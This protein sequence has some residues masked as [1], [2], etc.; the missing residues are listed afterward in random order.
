MR[1][2]TVRQRPRQQAVAVVAGHEGKVEPGFLEERIQAGGIARLEG[3]RAHAIG[4]S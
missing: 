4:S 1:R 2:S 3:Y